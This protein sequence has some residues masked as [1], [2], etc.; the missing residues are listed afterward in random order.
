M[1]HE[2]KGARRASE[3]QQSEKT[4]TVTLSRI[5]N[6]YTQSCW[7]AN[8]AERGICFPLFLLFDHQPQS[9]RL[10][11]LQ[12]QTMQSTTNNLFLVFF[13]EPICRLFPAPGK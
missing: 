10:A 9:S 2:R 7:I 11:H 1:A 4:L 12:S 5:T 3:A 8:P 6:A 13:K